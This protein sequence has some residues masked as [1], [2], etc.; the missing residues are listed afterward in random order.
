MSLA[1]FAEAT[2]TKKSMPG[3]VIDTELSNQDATVYRNNN[4]AIV[5]FSGTRPT[6]KHN[7][8]RDLTTDLGLWAGQKSHL[9]RFQNA[10]DLSNRAVDKYGKENVT[11]TGHSLGGSQ[12]VYVNQKLGIKGSAYNPYFDAKDVLTRKHFVNS[13]FD[14]H[15][16]LGDP[17]SLG[18][19]NLIGQKHV[20]LHTPMSKYANIIEPIITPNPIMEIP[21]VGEVAAVVG[22]VQTGKK[23][24]KLHDIKNFTGDGTYANKL[25]AR[26]RVTNQ[27]VTPSTNQPAFRTRQ[28]MLEYNAR[29]NL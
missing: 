29:H 26:E 8:W 13:N 16:I 27:P 10:L 25:N 19:V 1:D 11:V 28:E 14:V 24:M 5:A 22:A 23:V 20:H 15:A 9:H 4:S 12:A 18:A 17:V 3:Y 21:Y 7:A 2:Y 6:S